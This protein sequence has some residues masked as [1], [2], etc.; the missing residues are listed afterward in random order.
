MV[1]SEDRGLELLANGLAEDVI[2]LLARV[3]GFFL[4]SR[5]SSF[6]FRNPEIPTSVVAKQLGVRYVVEGS[7]RGTSDQVRVSIQLAEAATGRIL[8]SRKFDA[9]RAETLDLQDDIARGI[10]VELEP[11]LTQAEIAVIRRQR[12][13]N[14]DAWGCYHQAAG[15]LGANGWNERTVLEAQKLPATG[16]RTRRRLRSRACA[17]RSSVS[18]R[19][20]HG[21]CGTFG[22]AYSSG[23]DGSRNGDCG[24][25]R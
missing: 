2:A 15:S 6:A 22:G 14:V 19:S 13:E 20:K 7:V 11:A 3:P 24:R 9:A 18:G 1:L 17:T 10:I 25:S 23:A 8:W 21:P 12:P 16:T 5:G 4:I